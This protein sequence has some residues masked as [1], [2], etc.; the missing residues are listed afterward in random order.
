[1]TREKN[2]ESILA[3]S[4]GFLVLY[5]IFSIKAFAIV[6]V[7]TTGIGLF[8]NYLTDKVSRGW[9]KFAH[10]LGAI[11]GKI[12]LSLIFFLILTPLAL[13][14]KILGKPSVKLKKE[15]ST[16]YTQR[17]HTFVKADLENVW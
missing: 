17:N 12:L 11:N 9:W 15:K 16:M 3:I 2:L 13:F 8:S 4:F 5:F 1:M 7:V 10:I 14:K 6:A